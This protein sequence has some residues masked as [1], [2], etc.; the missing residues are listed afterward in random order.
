MNTTASSEHVPEMFEEQCLLHSP[1]FP[2]HALLVDLS[3]IHTEACLRAAPQSPQ[4]HGRQGNVTPPVCTHIPKFTEVTESR[5]WEWICV[6]WLLASW[7]LC[8]SMPHHHLNDDLNS[9]FLAMCLT[10]RTS[11][12]LLEYFEVNTVCMTHFCMCNMY[13]ENFILRRSSPCS[14]TVMFASHLNFAGMPLIK[15]DLISQHTFHGI[16]HF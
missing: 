15:Y 8:L 16:F 3:V 11:T 10:M 1:T 6:N 9:C 5:S 2:L 4:H 13:H 7:G 12:N 14:S